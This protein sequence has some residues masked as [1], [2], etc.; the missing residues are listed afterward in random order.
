[1]CRFVGYKGA[2][3]QIADLLIKSDNSLIVQYI[4]AK[5]SVKP[6]NGDGFGVGWYPVHNDP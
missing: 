2:P 4:N 3:I 1:M 6:V 5:E